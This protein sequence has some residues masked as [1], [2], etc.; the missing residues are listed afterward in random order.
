MSLF[1]GRMR[2]VTTKT[3]CTG[4]GNSRIILREM[5]KVEYCLEIKQRRLDA[6]DLIT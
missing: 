6:A 1:I 5:Q 4:S 3:P 2:G